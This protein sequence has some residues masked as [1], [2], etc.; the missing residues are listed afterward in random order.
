MKDEALHALRRALRLFHTAQYER[1][2]LST[3][4]RLAVTLASDGKD[5]EA[6]Q[7]YNTVLDASQNGIALFTVSAQN[8]PRVTQL[9]VFLSRR[10]CPKHVLTELSLRFVCPQRNPFNRA[11]M[12]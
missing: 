2:A 9:R 8:E 1:G 7:L 6:F 10:P 3:T 5:K 4:R 11:R 12:Q